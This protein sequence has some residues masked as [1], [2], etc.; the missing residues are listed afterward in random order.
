MP[1]P[2]LSHRLDPQMAAALAKSATLG[3]GLERVSALSIPEIRRRYREERRYWNADR[4]ELPAVADDSVAGPVGPVPIRRYYPS[5]ARA[6]PALVFAHGGGWIMGDL[7]THDKIMRLLARG[8]G[9]AVVGI[10][11]SLSPE[12]KFPVAIEE[13]VALFAALEAE[14]EAWGIDPS[15]LAM[16]GDSAGASLTV[17]TALSLAPGVLKAALLYY[18]AYGLTDSVSRRLYGGEGMSQEDMDFYSRSHLASEADRNDPRRHHLRAD[19]SALPP[20]FI[21]AAELDPIHDDSLALAA[22]AEA[23]GVA[24]RLEVYPGLPHGFLHY[25]RVV[26]KASQAIE[27]GAAF[28]REQLGA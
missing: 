28:L 24:Q 9:M 1:K 18:G 22:L 27:D 5:D 11:Y 19:L 7:D 21:A 25:S 12:R 8:S 3:P 17:G 10:D 20:L 15:R 6:L 23:Q 16:G 26:R 13:C 14:G 2:D 4:P